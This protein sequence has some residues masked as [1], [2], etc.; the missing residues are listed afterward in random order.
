MVGALA[1]V[2]VPGA[3]DWKSALGYANT[4]RAV[5]TDFAGHYPIRSVTKSYTVTLV[6]QM[7]R[8]K[9]IA[10]DDTLDAFIPGIPNGASITI[11]QL[12]GMRSGIADYSAS[13]AFIAALSADFGRPFTEQALVDYA[14]PLSPVFAPGTQ[15]QYSNTNTVLLGMIV[16]Q[17]LGMTL[18]QALQSRIFGPLGLA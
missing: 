17:R 4:A 16:Q 15:Y 13:P 12:A 10:L 9:L 6:L 2:R 1:S 11:E 3:A 5:P 14:I 7:V 18:A 8:D